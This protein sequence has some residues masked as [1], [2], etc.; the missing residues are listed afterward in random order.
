M[1]D[2]EFSSIY[3]FPEIALNHGIKNEIL[4]S[5]IQM[6]ICVPGKKSVFAINIKDTLMS[7]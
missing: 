6:M 3:S 1:H 5:Y 2:S 7:L 4:K